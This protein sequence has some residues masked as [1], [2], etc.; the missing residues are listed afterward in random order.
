MKKPLKSLAEV[1]FEAAGGRVWWSADKKQW[2]RVAR[3]VIQA[4]HRKL[5]R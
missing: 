2:N 1:A 5:R 4:Y 3:A